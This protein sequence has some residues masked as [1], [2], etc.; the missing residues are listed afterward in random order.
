MRTHVTIGLVAGMALGASCGPQ[1]QFDAACNKIIR[2]Y[3]QHQYECGIVFDELACQ[4]ETEASTFCNPDTPDAK[5][6]SCNREFNSVGCGVSIEQTC[7]D[8][9]CDTELGCKE[10]TSGCTETTTPNGEHGVVCPE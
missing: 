9:L 6:D 8:I 1:A 4:E 3:C 2:T 5:F 10:A 7:L